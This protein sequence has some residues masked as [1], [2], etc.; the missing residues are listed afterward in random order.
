VL[1]FSE[2]ICLCTAFAALEN[3]A[4]EQ[5]WKIE[6]MQGFLVEETD[7]PLFLRLH[8][9]FTYGCQ[10]VQAQ[11]YQYILLIYLDMNFEYNRDDVNFRY[12]ILP[13]SPPPSLSLSLSL[14]QDILTH[15]TLCRLSQNLSYSGSN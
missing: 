8:K 4:Q 15:V 3:E 11:L 7:C 5:N 1:K 2:V 12:V 13:L 10:N 14:T 6:M 9:L